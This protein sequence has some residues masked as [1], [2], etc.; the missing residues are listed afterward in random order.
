MKVLII[1]G[2]SIVKN[3]SETF[4][5][6]RLKLRRAEETSNLDSDEEPNRRR[7]RKV[8]TVFLPGES[9]SDDESALVRGRGR[10]KA[11]ESGSL[12]RSQGS[13]AVDPYPV[14]PMP[15]RPSSGKCTMEKNV[16]AGPCTYKNS[17]CSG[18]VQFIK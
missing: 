9:E 12:T 2:T 15:I 8:R 5:E 13:F 11:G 18:N 1:I 16:D 3:L 10:G 4:S 6:A 7:K 14:A 17:E